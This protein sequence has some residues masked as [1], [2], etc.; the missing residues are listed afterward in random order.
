MLSTNEAAKKLG[1]AASTLSRYIILGKIPA[2]KIV[3]AGL[4][5]VHA[6]TEEEIEAVRKLL[7][8]LK[9][10]RKTRYKKKQAA[11]TRRAQAGAP[12]L[13]KQKK[14]K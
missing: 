4:S 14:K 3:T 11:K 7:P 2:P 1:L 9:N 5:T 6:W 10:G 12:T 13:Q 8:K